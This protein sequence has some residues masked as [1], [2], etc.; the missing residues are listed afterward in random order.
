M[1]SVKSTGEYTKAQLLA[2]TPAK[3]LADGFMAGRG[4]TKPELQNE[5]ATAAATQLLEGEVSPQELA[6]TYE[7]LRQTL[8]LQTGP[9]SKRIKAALDETL[10]T[11]RGLIRQGN[12]PA[13]AKWLGQCGAAVKA[14]GDIDALLTHLLAVLRLYSVFV[15]AKST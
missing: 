13:L 8:P 4:K 9:P 10:E 7:A 14:P 1:K 12:N 5:Y 15:A 11:V 3:Y 6:F 2:L